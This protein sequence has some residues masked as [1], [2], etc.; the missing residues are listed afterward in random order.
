[1][2]HKIFWLALLG[3]AVMAQAVSPSFTAT[4]PLGGQR[5]TEMELLLRGD[6]LDDA[7]EVFFYGPGLTVLKLE[8]IKNNTLKAR[9]QIAPDC[10]IGEHALRIR[11]A[12]GVSDVRTFWVGPFPTVEEKEP[13]NEPAKAQSIP[14]NVTIQGVVEREDVDCFVVEAKQGDRIAVE[15][16]GIRLGRTV[17]DSLVTILDESGQV[18]KKADGSNLVLQDAIVSVVAPKAGRY[19]VQLR[20][21]AYGGSANHFYRMHVGNFPRPLAVYPA[22][23]RAGETLSVNFIGD[24]KGEFTRPFALPAVPQEKFGILAQQDEH[25]APSPNWLR[26]SSFPNILEAEP[27]NDQE[28]ATATE[29]ELTVALNGILS[30]N[31]DT[32]WFRFKA[33]KGQNFEVNVFARRI[34][35]SLDPVVQ[36]FD[37]KGKSLAQND[38][39]AGLD[40]YVRFSV[41]ADGEYCLKVSDQ[42]SKG[43]PEFTYRVEINQASPAVSLYIPDVARNNTQERKSI[44]VPKGNRFATLVAVRRLNFNG[45]LVLQAEGLPSGISMEADPWLAKLDRIPVVFEA[46]AD[47]PV[48]GSFFNL[49]A[50][51]PDSTKPVSGGVQQNFDMVLVNNVGTYH[52]FMTDKLA[53]AVAEEV[54]F[55]LSIIE[56]KTPLVQFGTLDLKISA[57]RQPGFDEPISVRMLWNPPGL[58]SVPDVTIPKGENSVTYRLNANGTADLHS[59]KIAVLGSSKVGAGTAWV[60]SQLARLSVAEPFLLLKLDRAITKPGQ[61]FK[62]IGK[63]DQKIPFEG[64]ASVKLMGLPAGCSTSEQQITKDDKEVVFEVTTDETAPVGSHRSLFCSVVVTQEGEPITFN[65]GNGGVLRIDA[66]KIVAAEAKPAAVSRSGPVTK[67]KSVSTKEAGAATDAVPRK[68]AVKDVARPLAEIKVFPPEVDLTTARD[69]QSLVVQA[70]YADGVTRDVTSEASFAVEN[71]AL[72]KLDQFTVFPL[73]DGETELKIQFEGKTLS[74]PVKVRH[75]GEDRPISFKLDVV[76]IFTKAGCNAGGCHGSSRGKDGFRLSLF[77]YDPEGDYQ[78]LTREMFG[79]R[80]NLALP[81]ES[82]ILEK[83]A[84]R[85]P[86]TGGER[87]KAEDELYQTILR[88]VQAGAP[89]DDAKVP[90]PVAIEIY[91]KQSVL[92]GTGASQR[93]TVRAKYSDGTDRDVTGLSVFLSNND[94]SAKVSDHG[95]VTAGQRGE[96]FVTARFHTFTVGAQVM[97]IPEGLKYVFPTEIAA[98]NYIDELVH[99]KLKK[100]RMIPSAVCDDATF[101]R[102]VYIDITG[103]LPTPDEVRKFAVDDGPTKRERIVD[104]LL[105]RKEFVDLWVMKWAEL[106]QIRSN[107]NQFSYRNALLYFGWLED[108]ITR[109]VPL[110]QMVRDLLTASGGTFKNPAASFYKVETDTLKLAENSAQVFM[111]MRI[112]CA[113]CHNH[114]FDRWTMDDYYNYASFFS[115]TGRK[116]GEDPREAIIFNRGSGEV[117]HPVAGRKPA[118]KFLGAEFADTQGK[119]RREVLADWLAS[120][121]NPYFARNLANQVWAHFFGQGIIDPVDDVRVSNPASNPELL[122][123]LAERFTGY[124]YNLRKFVRDLC[125][126]RT[127]QLSA[128]SNETNAGDDRNFAKAKIRRL[129][130]EMLLDS[131]NQ[132]TEFTDKFNGLPR[133]SRAV[134]IADGNTTTY[135]L[136]TFGRATRESVCSCEVKMEPNLSQALHLLNGDATTAKIQNGGTVRRL[137]RDGK[138]KEQVIEEIYLRCLARSPTASELAQFLEFFKDEK[139]TEQTLNDVFWSVLNAKEFIFNH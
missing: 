79:R 48:A 89:K 57:E 63:L 53:A 106:L 36:I 139:R 2:K 77:G 126:S 62:L 17:F 50:S 61:S 127:Y 30:Q 26:V 132:V 87:F 46:K 25:F 134:Q 117:N 130:A 82:L 29:L 47:A 138:T 28:H 15:V 88:W 65:V 137:L 13:N 80:V 124:Q 84:G 92:E 114:P 18:L 52:Q 91:P 136:T 71:K 33:Q 109:N 76:P 100:L 101:L 66:P 86:H 67:A 116:N 103:T 74:I 14:M 4:S 5:G 122:D 55:K 118:P 135:F 110:D 38:D 121:K 64:K 16:E 128:Q 58:A 40:S 129:R 41:P 9:I 20:E 105:D 78:R 27:N 59:W 45:D 73:A 23:G 54:P 37:A 98:H 10:R 21:T 19:F 90:S 8:E 39:S 7:Q 94:V 51:S 56:P 22:G 131:I 72:A 35:S 69:G 12:T 81:E 108:Q 44:V 1:M 32:D 99:A 31:G 85:V 24:A 43:G 42:L 115:Q 133:G 113:Q 83:G 123:A 125:L 102:R 111:G 95:V 93:L 60:S 34:R 3:S 49:T 11:T 68:E 6:R 104:A 119:D 97:V 107:Q 70:S 96:S 112:Q 75:A 120:P